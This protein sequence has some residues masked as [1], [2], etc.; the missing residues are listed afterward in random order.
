M[1][2]STSRRLRVGGVL[3]AGMAASTVLAGGVPARAVDC[4]GFFDANGDGRA[5]LP[6]GAPNEDV[7]GAVN[8]GSVTILMGTASGS[9]TGTGSTRIVQDQIGDHSEAQDRMGASIAIVDWNPAVDSCPDLAIGI[10]GENGSRG[11]VI[12]VLSSTSGLNLGQRVILGQGVG[13]AS[14]SAEA[15]DRFGEAMVASGVAVSGTAQALAVGT[16]GEDVGTAADAGVV[17]AFRFSSSNGLISRAGRV[18][19]Q[20]ANGIP[21]TPEAGDGFGSSLAET[22]GL[23]NQVSVV[24][25]PGEDIGGV[26]DAGMVHELDGGLATHFVT[27]HQNSPRVPDSNE[28]G[29]RFGAAVGFAPGPCAG[30]MFFAALMIGAPGENIGGASDAGTVT[31]LEPENSADVGNLIRQGAGGIPDQLEAG[32]R[33]GSSITTVGVETAVGAP[34]EDVGTASDG[35]AVVLAHI[36]CGPGEPFE[37]RDVVVLHGRLFTENSSGVPDA[38]E[39]G[40]QFG[41]RLAAARDTSFNERLIVAA[42]RENVATR[43]G[44]GAVFAFPLNAE[45]RVA[46]GS[47]SAYSQNTTGVPDT[48]EANDNFGLG[49]NAG[50]G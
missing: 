50:L 11:R 8:A 21:D 23:P 33:F 15:G 5:D 26:T 7:S 36:G 42:T 18:V 44:A 43:A 6:V 35:G 4:T 24:G 40:D 16:P 31:M 25:V 3:V 30:A 2:G 34:G 38:A 32:D 28:A 47:G 48:A 45:A 49:L 46:T 19:R 13:G 10:P 39:D 17:M 41:G 20:G 1:N 12:V 14:D 27:L 22:G 37:E 29:D 9:Y